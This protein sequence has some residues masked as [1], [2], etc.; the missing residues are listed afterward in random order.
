MLYR[1]ENYFHYDFT[2]AGKRFRGSTRQTSESRARKVESKLIAKAEQSGPSAVLRRAQL[3][4]VFGPRFLSWVNDGRGLAANTRRYYRLGLQRIT[5]TQLMGMTLDRITTEEVDGLLLSGSP[6]YV[7]QGLRTLRR[8]L[9]KAVEWKVIAVAPR[10]R[11]LPEPERQ[12]V[13]DPESEAKLVAVGKQPLNDVLVIIQDTGMR[14]DE[15]FRVRIENIDFV[16]RQI[17]NP[18]GKTASRRYVPMSQRMLDM[19]LLR[20]AGKTEGW[21]FPCAKAKSGHRTTVAKQFREARQEAGLPASL[22]LYCARHAFGTAIYEGTGNLAMVMKVMGH[23]DVRTAMR[24]QHP[25]LD[26]VRGSHRPAQFTSQSTS[27]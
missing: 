18:N 24:Y 14:P 4:S 19:L 27:Q 7:N 12:Q 2:V 16:A 13:L 6:S 23:T 21:L 11:L 26:P 20:C 5:E 15:V 22:V 1:R 8:L 10:I 3:L 9:G 17:F 25:I